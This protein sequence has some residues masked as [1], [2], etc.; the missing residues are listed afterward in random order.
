MAVGSDAMTTEDQWYDDEWFFGDEE[1]L[2]PRPRPR[3]VRWIAALAVV[4]V[5]AGG[6]SAG[7]GAIGTFRQVHSEAVGVEA[8]KWIDESPWG[9]IVDQVVVTTIAQPEVGAYVIEGRRAGIIFLDQ[10]SWERADMEETLAHEIG[11]LIDFSIWPNDGI[12]RRGGLESEVW[13]ECSAVA[14]GE[15]SVD[16]RSNNETYRCRAD[17]LAVYEQEMLKVDEVCQL[18]RERLCFRVIDGRPA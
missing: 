8:Q 11:H 17:E 10:R 14:Q 13:A 15:R 1:E 12:D 4:A 6:I 5:L 16:G 3:W 7:I 2:P 18:V 9:F